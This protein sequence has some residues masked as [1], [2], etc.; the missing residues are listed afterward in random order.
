MA[1][2]IPHFREYINYLQNQMSGNAVDKTKTRSK[3]FTN[4]VSL[5]EQRC[6]NPK[7]QLCL[8]RLG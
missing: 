7:P 4:M 8:S 3:M 1:E 5:V 6:Q 2:A